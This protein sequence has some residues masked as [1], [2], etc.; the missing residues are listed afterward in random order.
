MTG[1]FNRDRFVAALEVVQQCGSAAYSF[2]AER[3]HILDTVASTNQTAWE[4]MEQ[5]EATKTVVVMAQAQTAGKG[6]WGRQWVSQPG[7][8]YLSVGTNLDVPIEQAAQLTLCTVWG[9]AIAL[10]TIPGQLSGVPEIIPVQ[11]KWLNDLVLQG[12]K[13]GG[14]LTETRIQGER[15]RRAVVGVGINWTN[16]VPDTGINLQTYL[17][18]LSIPLIESLEMLAAITLHGVFSGL[19][20]WQHRGI[21]AILAGY[22]DLLAHRDRVIAVEGQSGTIVGVLPTGELRVRLV[23]P[24]FGVEKSISSGFGAEIFIK[25]GTI[26]LGYGNS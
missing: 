25:P 15:I 20:E 8:L 11:I 24:K 12:R 21:D 7:G 23:D 3:S 26:S 16:T 4:W 13:L 5:E 18:S 9:I 19:W 6:Q 22:G 17:E 14:I 10:R 1:S 2:S